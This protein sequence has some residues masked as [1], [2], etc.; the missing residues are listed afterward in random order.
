MGA[1]N[2]VNY[3]ARPDA[4]LGAWADACGSSKPATI[5]VP[6]GSFFG[7]AKIS[8]SRS[9]LMDHWVLV[10]LTFKYVDGLSIFGQASGLQDGWRELSIR[11]HLQGAKIIAPVT[12]QHRRH[13]YPN[14]SGH[15][16]GPTTASRSVRGRAMCGLRRSA[17]VPVTAL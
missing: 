6:A 3:G 12:A 7:P 16:D 2:V 14:S 9:T 4:F 10:W 15:K 8:I 1:Y 17:A 13:P 5:Y 11:N